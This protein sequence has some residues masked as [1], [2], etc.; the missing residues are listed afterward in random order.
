MS[1]NDNNMSIYGVNNNNFSSSI[2]SIKEEVFIKLKGFTKYIY[3]KSRDKKMMEM[4]DIMQLCLKLFQQNMEEMVFSP[5]NKISEDVMNMVNI[6]KNE[7]KTFNDDNEYGKG[8]F[9]FSH[10]L[11]NLYEEIII[12]IDYSD[13]IIQINIPKFNDSIILDHILIS[14]EL[15]IVI[16]KNSFKKFQNTLQKEDI[17][18]TQMIQC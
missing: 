6:L 10:H 8:V 18:L 14:A 7:F 3:N 5:K 4:M 9:K 12:I 2:S 1:D 15:Q 17:I 16:P 13:K 11:A